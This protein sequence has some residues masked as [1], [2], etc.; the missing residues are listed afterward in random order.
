GVEGAP[1]VTFRTYLDAI[2][3]R[4]ASVTGS[5]GTATGL[6]AALA[7]MLPRPPEGWTV[8]P[9]TAEDID[10]FLPKK[11]GDGTPEAR[12]LVKSVGSTRVGKGAE[13][14]IL[15][16]EKGER[17]VTVQAVRFPDRIFTD[18]AA[19]EERFDLQMQAAL[20][21]GRSAMTVRGLD[22]TEG[23]LGDG[24]RARY[25]FADVGAQIQIRMLASK[26][27]DDADIVTFLETLHVKAMNAN[28]VDQQAGLGDLPVITL[29][30]AMT[31]AGREAYEADR[32]ERQAGAV[33]RAE[34]QRAA[35]RAWLASVTPAQ[36]GA[37]VETVVEKPETGFTTTCAKGDGGIT[38][39]TVGAGN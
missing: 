25:F 30:S 15:T 16:Y 14:V 18:D 39:C 21:P 11:K 27:L 32:A 8:R 9:A 36:D 26:R 31:D 35:A 34:D 2:P 13:V 17:R 3:G 1:E 7:D 38:R 22:V 23:F 29:A 33:T 28:V 6:P 37:T 20:Q 24:M 12:D 4:I 19:H 10:V 5:S